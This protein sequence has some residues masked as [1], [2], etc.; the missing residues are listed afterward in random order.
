MI[1]LGKRLGRLSDKASL[2]S[3]EEYSGKFLV[4]LPKSLHRQLAE[5]AEREGVSLNQWITAILS[6][7]VGSS[8]VLQPEEKREEDDMSV[9]S[10]GTNKRAYLVSH[11]SDGRICVRVCHDNQ[12]VRATLREHLDNPRYFLEHLS[13]YEKN[14]FRAQYWLGEVIKDY[15]AYFEAGRVVFDLD[16]DC[17]VSG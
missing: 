1:N 10:Y 17:G 4:R 16:G 8:Q 11:L 2:E 3:E 9:R 13:T 5:E 12:L 6:R 15:R 7:A 14:H